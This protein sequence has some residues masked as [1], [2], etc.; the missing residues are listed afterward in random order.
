MGCGGSS[1]VHVGG[2]E[3]DWQVQASAKGRVYALAHQRCS[4]KIY[5]LVLSNKM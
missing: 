5:D 3:P 1:A 4:A 2:S